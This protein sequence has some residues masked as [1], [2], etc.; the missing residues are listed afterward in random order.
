MNQEQEPIHG[1]YML[2]T[3]DNP[4]D[5]FVDFDKWYN[6]DVSHGYY[7]C[8]ILGALALT[9]D[10]VSEAINSANID[11][12]VRSIL[13]TDYENLYKIVYEKN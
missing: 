7:T 13:S 12:A 3:N 2:T 10:G 4:Y 6:F 8:Q 5:P 1:N 9:S 11:E